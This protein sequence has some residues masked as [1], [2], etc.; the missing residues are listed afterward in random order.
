MAYIARVDDCS[1]DDLYRESEPQDTIEKALAIG[2][3]MVIDL[4]NYKGHDGTLEIYDQGKF[5]N[6]VDL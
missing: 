2:D 6:V 5:L 1:T 4:H 3:Q